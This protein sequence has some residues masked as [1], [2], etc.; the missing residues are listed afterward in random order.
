MFHTG[1]ARDKILREEL[2]E[3]IHDECLKTSVLAA[4]PLRV[5][6]TLTTYRNS[7]IGS[8]PHTREQY[9]PHRVLQS[10]TGGSKLLCL[11]SQNLPPEWREMNLNELFETPA[12]DDVGS[13]EV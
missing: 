11:D 1:Q 5:E 9:D 3:K 8:V 10:I 12:G 4:L 6:N 2:H 7:L 13:A